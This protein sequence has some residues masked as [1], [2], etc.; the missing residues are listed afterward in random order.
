LPIV[1][2]KTHTDK[3]SRISKMSV[4]FETGRVFI[5]PKLVYLADELLEFPRGESDDLADSLSFAIEVA[6]KEKPRDWNKVLQLVETRGGIHVVK[7]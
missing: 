1:P 7:V 5:N 3:I 2:V 4:Y 6:Q